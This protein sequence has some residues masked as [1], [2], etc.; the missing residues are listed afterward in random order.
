MGGFAAG[1]A[2][3]VQRFFKGLRL[4]GGK[5]EP[6]VSYQN[7]TMIAFFFHCR[8]LHTVWTERAAF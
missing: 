2:G 1:D 5:G 7:H 4:P 8:P 6:D 3:Q